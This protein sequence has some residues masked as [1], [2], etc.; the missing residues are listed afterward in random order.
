M[1]N[2]RFRCSIVTNGQPVLS[3]IISDLTFLMQRSSCH[4]IMSV[5]PQ[6]LRATCRILALYKCMNYYYNYY[7]A[8]DFHVPTDTLVQNYF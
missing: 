7:L 1:S 5:L 6:R 4:L 3:L 2:L 8:A